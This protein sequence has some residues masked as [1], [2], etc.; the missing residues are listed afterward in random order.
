MQK[1]AQIIGMIP[2]RFAS[3]RL[4]GKML[5]PI[6]GKSLIQ[7]TYDNAKKFVELDDLI[8]ATDDERIYQHV[9]GFGGKA[10]MTP[11]ECQNGTE[12]LSFMIKTYPEYA[13]AD[14]I[15]NIQGDEP[16]LPAAA[17]SAVT[18]LLVEDTEAVMGTAALPIFSKEEAFNPS[19][20]KCV[21]DLQGNAL[22]FSRSPISSYKH[23]GIYC[24]RPKFLVHY[25]SL[26]ST[27][28]QERESL[29]QL[30]VLEHGY[31]MKVALIDSKHENVGVDTLEDVKKLEKLLGG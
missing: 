29:E 31:R 14:Y 6:L 19:C 28:H 27:P 11:Q 13:Q 16:L 12:R 30:K 5:L 20:V 23:L 10:F 3:T 9:K 22:Y 18:K 17:V 1:R 26:P 24:Y 7:R 2:A 8:V 15:L 21:M 4:P 25:A